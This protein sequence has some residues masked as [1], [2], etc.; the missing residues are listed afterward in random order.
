MRYVGFVRAVMVGRE[1]L[2]G[3]VLI[4]AFEKAGATAVRS[5]LTTGN[6]T[7]S[8]DGRRLPTFTRSVDVAL[9]DVVGRRIEVF[10]RTVRELAAVDAEAIYAT[11]PFEHLGELVSYFHRPPDFG[12]LPVPSVVHHGRAAILAI[13]GRDV[14]SVEREVDGRRSAPGGVF[15]RITGQRCT[16]RGWSTVAKILQREIG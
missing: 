7:F 11:A 12:G 9:S 8:L 16:T 1:G 14:Y 15:E 13:E 2:H 5:H 3:D 6:V 10:V 4:S